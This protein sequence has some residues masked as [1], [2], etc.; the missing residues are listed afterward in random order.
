[1]TNEEYILIQNHPMPGREW[2]VSLEI[3][4]GLK[5]R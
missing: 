1:M 5:K 4:Y 2:G 3:I